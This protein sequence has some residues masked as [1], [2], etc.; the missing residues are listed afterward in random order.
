VAHQ[1][2]MLAVQGFNDA[3]LT[4]IGNTSLETL[5]SGGVGRWVTTENH[6]QASHLSVSSD[7]VLPSLPGLVKVVQTVGTLNP[8]SS[9]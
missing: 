7:G 3:H 9:S 4:L 2:G 8:S 1:A 5:I 6:S